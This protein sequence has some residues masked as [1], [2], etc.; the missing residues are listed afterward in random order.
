MP[1]V[2][3]A[4]RLEG[5]V[6]RGRGPEVAPPL[7]RQ[8]VPLPHGPVLDPAASP[9]PPGSPSS[10]SCATASP[11]SARPSCAASPTRRLSTGGTACSPRY[12]ATRTGSCCATPSGL[13][14]PTSTTP[15][16]PRATG[17]PGSAA[18]PASSSASASPSTGT[19]TRSRSPAATASPVRRA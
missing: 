3:R 7:L 19:R 13:T 12:P 5:R 16:S 6:H 18:Y 2:R 14:R 17:R 4:R 1:G 15:T 10:G 11:S 8:E 9:S